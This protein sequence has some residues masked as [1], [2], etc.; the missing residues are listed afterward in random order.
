MR[1]GLPDS[2]GLPSFTFSF[3]VP[4][5]GAYPGS[6]P[7]KAPGPSQ[8]E[9]Q[10]RRQR[11]RAEQREKQR[12]RRP[13]GPGPLELALQQVGSREQDEDDGPPT[14]TPKPKRP[15]RPVPHLYIPQDR[16]HERR[17]PRQRMVY[18]GNLPQSITKDEIQARLKRVGTTKS[19]S[20]SCGKGYVGPG[21]TIDFP[22]GEYMAAVEFAQT[23]QAE[24]AVRKYHL[25]KWRDHTI[26]VS[27]SAWDMPTG[28]RI[29]GAD[30]SKPPAHVNPRPTPYGQVRDT[31][32][33]RRDAALWRHTQDRRRKREE[34][35]EQRRAERVKQ[36]LGGASFPFTVV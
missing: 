9:V 26:M 4:M 28:R 17:R 6:P 2:L 23:S 11:S 30:V 19:I 24:R 12:E 36:Q 31:G 20:I 10:L 15:A 29:R 14:P 5:P 3:H 16:G 18:I 22:E 33:K 1:F 8:P 13:R 25:T 27:F 35:V 21:D 7:P 34:Q 32:A